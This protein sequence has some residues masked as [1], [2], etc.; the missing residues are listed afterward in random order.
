MNV[1]LIPLIRGA[2]LQ[3]AV[4]AFS[5]IQEIA[6]VSGRSGSP[7]LRTWLLWPPRHGRHSPFARLRSGGSATVERSCARHQ[8]PLLGLALYPGGTRIVLPSIAASLQDVGDLV[9][10]TLVSVGL[11]SLWEM[12]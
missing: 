3:S 4:S 6:R 1:V 12:S 2:T 10:L 11:D 5:R 9:S 7:V 8:S